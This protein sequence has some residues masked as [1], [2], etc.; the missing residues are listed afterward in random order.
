MLNW[1]LVD[2]AQASPSNAI[3]S[4]SLARI[5]WA[6]LICATLYVCYFSHLDAIGFVGPDEPRY[7]WIARDMAESGDWITPRLYGKPWFEKPPLYYWSAAL[8]FKLFG[9]S[10]A[11]A[12]LPGALAALLA[13]LALGWLALRVYSAETAR[14]LLL[15]LPTSVAMIGFSHAASTDMLFS[16]CLTLALVT[17]AKRLQLSPAASAQVTSSSSSTAFLTSLFFGFFLGLAVLAKGPAAIILTGGAVFCWALFT[18][19]WRGAFRLL[20]PAAIAAFCL[21]ALPWY[22]LCARRNS[23]FFRV[24]IIEHNFKRFLTPEFQHV[25]PFSYYAVVL[26]IALLPWTALLLWSVLA[27]A[28]RLWRT[29]CTSEATC[30]LLC[31]AGF[32]VLFFSISKSK[33]PGYILPAIPA[34]ALLMVRAGLVFAIGRSKSLSLSVLGAGFLFAVAFALAESF[35]WTSHTSTINIRFAF[36]A[37]LLLGAL[38]AA[39]FLLGLGVSSLAKTRI[40]AAVAAC[41][42]LPM[43]LV[44]TFSNR[45][46][47]WLF[48][49]D[50]AGRT[51]AQEL[52]RGEI[53]ADQLAVATMKR[54]QRYSLSFYLHSE[55]VEWDRENRHAGYLLTGSRMCGSIVG[56][57]S[58][59]EELPF[60]FEKTGFF[61]YRITPHSPPGAH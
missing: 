1:R 46:L 22:I 54:A 19:R 34:I 7:A 15:L 53:P 31:W 14:W 29:R 9:V 12:R 6:I 18:K 30:L 47:P 58:S 10:E 2:S 40:G 25:Q 35:A 3:T 27:G 5:A 4:S 36:A 21:T 39:N 23:D 8:S 51:L 59:C 60:S 61:L 44:M 24:F 17:A 26:L 13:T 42:V 55:I 43:L 38:S 41:A 50:P 32:C 33:L 48:P 11:A 28:I 45:L 49:W 16:A 37:G 20:H 56:Q 57:E 52:R